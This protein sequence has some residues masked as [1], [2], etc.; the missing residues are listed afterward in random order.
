MIG[1]VLIFGPRHGRSILVR[2][3]VPSEALLRLQ[4]R[5]AELC[6]AEPEGQFSSRPVESARDR[7]PPD[8]D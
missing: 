8:A 5:V 7:G 1:A 6:G 2:S 3:V 4:A